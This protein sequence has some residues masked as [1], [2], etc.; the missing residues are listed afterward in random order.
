MA[1]PRLR[2]NTTITA[3]GNEQQA[4]ATQLA[5]SPLP[6]ARSVGYPP[7]SYLLYYPSSYGSYTLLSRTSTA[8]GG[9]CLVPTELPT[10]LSTW[11]SF[12][13]D[14]APRLWHSLWRS[15]RR[16]FRVCTT[17][18]TTTTDSCSATTKTAT[19][20]H[21]PIV[22]VVVAFARHVNRTMDHGCR[23]FASTNEDCCHISAATDSIVMHVHACMHH[24]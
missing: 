13:I 9:H 8:L 11:L 1:A 6:K 19:L 12:A 16:T 23:L 4:T 21:Y 17:T 20:P 5:V 2:L 14:S 3:T 15:T 24:E 22:V 18:T 10:I 7:F